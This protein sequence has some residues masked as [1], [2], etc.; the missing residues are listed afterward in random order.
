MTWQRMNRYGTFGVYRR[1]VV[2]VF[3]RLFQ[4]IELTHKTSFEVIL[5]PIGVFESSSAHEMCPEGCQTV[6]E[7]MSIV[8]REILFF[9]CFDW[10]H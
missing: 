3:R 5:T 2:G 9:Q 10:S 7:P 4:E 6:V 8:S 1:Q